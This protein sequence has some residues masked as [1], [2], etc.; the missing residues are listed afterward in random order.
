MKRGDER[1]HGTPIERLIDEALGHRHG[2]NFGER[3]DR[4][5]PAGAVRALERGVHGRGV[6]V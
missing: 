3:L 6:G 4:H 2:E 1:L 5:R